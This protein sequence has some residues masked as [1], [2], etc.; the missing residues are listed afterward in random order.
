MYDCSGLS[1]QE[2]K[3]Q[4]LVTVKKVEE[5]NTSLHTCV[6]ELW[7]YDHDTKQHGRRGDF[8]IQSL[9]LQRGRC[10]WFINP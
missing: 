9:H 7:G 5:E 4:S 3:V 6:L 10:G 1:D 2:M 8:Y